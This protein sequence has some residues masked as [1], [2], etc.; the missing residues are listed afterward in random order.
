MKI[1][2]LGILFQCLNTLSG[3]SFDTI[4]KTFGNK[5]FEWHHYY[6]IG[7]IVS[8]LLFLL[9]LYFNGGIKN[10]I[11][12]KTKSSYTIPLLR[13]L[14]FIPIPIIVFNSIKHVPLNVFTSVL[15]TTPFFILLFSKLLQNEKI[16]INNL[17]ILIIGF[18]GA[19]MVIK[20]SIGLSNYYIYAILLVAIHNA[21]TNIVVSKYSSNATTYGY[22]F[23]Y[24][25]PLTVVAIIFFIADPIFPELFDLLMIITSGI[26]IMLSVLFWTA[27][28]HIAGKY[29]RIISPFLFT[30]LI[31]SSIF[32]YIYFGEILDVIAVIGIIL[33]IISGSISL[34]YTKKI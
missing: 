22:T 12:L 2:L 17:V 20:P 10:N 18:G 21:I 26:F 4:T 28:F 31:W 1:I 27:A 29:S 23:Y 34:I 13:G 7:N 30:Q 24:F 5:T 14:I 6:S 25:L 9:Y 3:A 16:T 33:I 32:G 19:Y 8:L 15:M 11:I